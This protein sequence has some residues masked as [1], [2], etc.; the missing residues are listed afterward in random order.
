MRRVALCVIVLGLMFGAKAVAQETF[1]L[2]QV[3][4]AP[5][6]SHL[7]AAK[8]G[9][10]LAWTLNQEGKR[11]IWVAEAPSFV[12]RQLSAYNEDD[13]GELSD[14][15]F[16]EDGNSVVFT[17]G[18]GKNSS[19]QYRQSHK[20]SRWRGTVRVDDWLERAGR[21]RRSTRA[22]LPRYQ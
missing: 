8:N 14:V 22:I 19:G 10:R 5:F 20:Q 9:S 4:S 6:A 2:Q 3:L 16:T 7:V 15:Q 12:A 21:Q 17:R 13:G 11:N 1:T 18:E